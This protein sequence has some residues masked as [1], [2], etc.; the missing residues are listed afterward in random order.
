MVP[1]ADL[2][3]PSGSNIFQKLPRLSTSVW[4]L[5]VVALVLVAVVP[6]ITAYIDAKSQQGPL[7]EKLS[8]LQSQYAGLQK[9][10]T[11]QGAADSQINQLKLDVEAVRSLYGNACDS[12]ETS[13]ELMNLA[14][15][16]DVV[17][18]GMQANPVKE[19]IQGKDYPCISYVLNMRGQVANF[20][21]YLIAVGN[22][23]PSSRPDAVRIQPAA[24]EGMLD[25]AMLTIRI[26]C[27]Q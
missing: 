13:Q 15:Q 10:V 4:L 3:K 7:K 17:I 24:A 6:M 2:K 14:W 22:K 8:R 27:N 9:Q 16:Y 1:P 20:Q 18:T 11:P 25:Y 26:I 5:I 21:N 23:F 12:V 19:K